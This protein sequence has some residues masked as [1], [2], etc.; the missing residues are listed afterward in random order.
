MGGIVNGEKD[1][2]GD[3]LRDLEHAREDQFFAEQDRALLSKLKAREDPA[4]SA[5]PHCGATLEPTPHSGVARCPDAH[6]LWLEASALASPL[7]GDVL[8]VLLAGSKR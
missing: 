2:F 5:C 6:G 7:S 3:K 8:G 4:A 1:R